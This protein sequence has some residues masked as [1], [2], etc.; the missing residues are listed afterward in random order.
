MRDLPGFVINHVASLGQGHPWAA[1]LP[2]LGLGF[3]TGRVGS[4]LFQS[5]SFC[6][7]TQET[8]VTVPT[9]I[10]PQM[11]LSTYN[12]LTPSRSCHIHIFFFFFLVKLISQ[13]YSFFSP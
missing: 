9:V 4:S 6:L 1:G 7:E 5:S 3:P 2:F 8:D 13:F 11:S 12:V 10:H